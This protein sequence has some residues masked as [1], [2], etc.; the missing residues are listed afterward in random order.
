MLYSG[1]FIAGDVFKYLF[2]YISLIKFP[3]KRRGTK[4]SGVID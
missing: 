4:G 2:V 1:F 3:F